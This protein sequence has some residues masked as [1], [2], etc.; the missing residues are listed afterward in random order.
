[1]QIRKEFLEEEIAKVEKHLQRLDKPVILVDTL[2]TQEK[3]LPKNLK[4]YRSSIK[5]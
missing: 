4:F 5:L 3:P 2:D 1:M